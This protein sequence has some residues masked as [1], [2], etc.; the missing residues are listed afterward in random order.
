MK[1]L[2]FKNDN[3][4]WR[5]MGF[6]LFFTL[7]ACSNGKQVQVAEVEDQVPPLALSEVYFQELVPGQ[8]G[9]KPYYVLAI[10]LKESEAKKLVSAQ[11]LEDN[12][13]LKEQADRY[14]GLCPEVYRFEKGDVPSVEI[15]YVYE[16]KQYAQKE[17]A[18]VKEPIYMP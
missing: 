10:V 7:S 14:T 1:L 11:V 12:I 15:L 5:L 16:G 9:A 3:T 6:I 17:Q 18:T 13:E 8:E 2:K 4:M